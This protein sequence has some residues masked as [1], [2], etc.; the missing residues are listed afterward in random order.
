MWLTVNFHLLYKNQNTSANWSYSFP[1]WVPVLNLVRLRYWVEILLHKWLSRPWKLGQG[2][3]VRTSSLP[4]PGASVYQILW[5]YINYFFI[6]WTETILNGLRD[7]ETKVKFSR[8]ILVST[9]PWFFCV[10]TFVKIRQIFPQIL[11][12][13]HLAYVV[14][15]NDLVTLKVRSRPQDSNLVFALPW[16]LCVPKFCESL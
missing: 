12:G 8:M 10:Q 9:L 15:L 4:C 2:H 7:L 6:Y 11:S 1:R 3:P 5:G 14:I 13:N 16:G